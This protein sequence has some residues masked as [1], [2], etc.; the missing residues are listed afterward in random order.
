MEGLPA[1]LVVV[2][3]TAVTIALAVLL[4]FEGLVILGRHLARR[5]ALVDDHGLRGH[6]AMLW[7]IA[8]LLLLHCLEIAMFGVAYWGLSHV[9]DV[10]GTHG[11]LLESMYLSATAYSTVGFGDVEPLIQLRFLVA[12]ESVVGLLLIAWSGSFTFIEMSRHWRSEL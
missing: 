5:T 7:V 9:L 6:W 12:I 4:H 1:L 8:G 11:G 2:V 10:A 3:A